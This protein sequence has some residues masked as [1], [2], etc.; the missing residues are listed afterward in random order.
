MYRWGHLLDGLNVVHRS[1]YCM[2]ERGINCMGQRM[3]DVHRSI[4]RMDGGRHLLCG[5]KDVQCAR[6]HLLYGW[7]RHLLCG[8]KDVHRSICRINGRGIYCRLKDVQ[9]AQKHLSYGWGKAFI[10]WVN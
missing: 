10:V 7:E 3:C 1:I 8:S 4:C 2:G 6:K 9:C 5:S